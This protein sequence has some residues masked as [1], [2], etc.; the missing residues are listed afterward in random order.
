M[1]QGPI[2]SDAT[3]SRHTPSML[4]RLTE[5]F[6]EH[7]ASNL[8][9]WM[10]KPVV[11]AGSA[12]ADYLDDPAGGGPGSSGMR[13]PVA[14]FGA[15][16]S[17]GLLDAQLSPLG[18]VLAGQSALKRGYGAV[19]DTFNLAEPTSV[20]ADPYALSDAA[21][22]RRQF[23]YRASGAPKKA[24][25]A[26]V[27]MMPKTIRQVTNALDSLPKYDMP[28]RAKQLDKIR[29]DASLAE[30][31]QDRHGVL[32]D[33]A[34]P[35]RKYGDYGKMNR[36]FSETYPLDENSNYYTSES[37][38]GSD[39]GNA[40]GNL[41]GSIS[42]STE[43]KLR[44]KLATLSRTAPRMENK[45]TDSVRDALND[46]KFRQAN[47]RQIYNDISDGSRKE[48]LDILRAHD[49]ENQT[50][51]YGGEGYVTSKQRQAG[52]PE[53][54]IDRLRKLRQDAGDRMVPV[55]RKL[56]ELD[57]QYR[58]LIKQRE[59]VRAKLD[60]P[61]F[62]KK[63]LENYDRRIAS[64]KEFDA[65]PSRKD[66]WLSNRLSRVGPDAENQLRILVGQIGGPEG[67]LAKQM[68]EA[69]LSGTSM[70]KGIEQA[71][72]DR[73]M[74]ELEKRTGLPISKVRDV[75]QAA[76]DVGDTVEELGPEKVIDDMKNA[77]LKRFLGK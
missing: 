64:A 77:L 17:K 55:R 26:R 37:E 30:Q 2:P 63:A 15:G 36:G 44:E 18:L 60:L 14:A 76:K 51:Y 45:V 73:V 65:G 25:Q 22:G 8:W 32:N 16:V 13:H 27:E 47:L 42:S 59:V 10:N 56:D 66:W 3:I 7:D 40:V 46:V 34:V 39:S 9:H 48:Q 33:N 49:L 35:P 58:E 53:E 61:D 75:T 31:L 69:H 50:S 43:R 54:V 52:Y 74:G 67:E 29:E 5:V 68:M 57:T 62:M 72:A 4:E 23:L 21:H 70:A 11:E 12:V 38:F 20:R 71:I 28:G 6:D 24:A 19:R 1:P 41:R